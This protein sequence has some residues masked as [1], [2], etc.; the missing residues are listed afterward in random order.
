MLV[1]KKTTKENGSSDGK[2]NETAK[3]YAVAIAQTMLGSKRSASVSGQQPWNEIE[4]PAEI[5]NVQRRGSKSSFSML[6]STAAD[7]AGGF[8][9]RVFSV[10]KIREITEHGRH[11]SFE[12]KN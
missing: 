4:E 2:I 11:T 8:N 1:A 7:S 12:K 9:L 10:I 6:R 5:R 3:Q